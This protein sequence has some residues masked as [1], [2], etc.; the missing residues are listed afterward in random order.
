[1]KITKSQLID[2]IEEELNNIPNQGPLLEAWFGLGEKKESDVDT[3]AYKLLNQLINHTREQYAMIDELKQRVEQLES[4][5][6]GSS[7][8]F[9]MP[10]IIPPDQEDVTRNIRPRADTE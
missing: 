4:Q 2:I 8:P 9:D 5:T 7:T 3:T 1:M 10:K 6:Q